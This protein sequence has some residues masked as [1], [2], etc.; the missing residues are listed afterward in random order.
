[1]RAAALAVRLRSKS[2]MYYKTYRNDPRW[3]TAKYPGADINGREFKRGEEVLYFPLGQC[4]SGNRFLSG[5]AAKK[6][7]SRFIAEAQD[8]EMFNASR[9]K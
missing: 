3:I 8:E 2:E 1:M 9:G 5:E 6:A 7:W 4:T